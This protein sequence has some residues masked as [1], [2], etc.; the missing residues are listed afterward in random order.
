MSLK[1]YLFIA[2][3]LLIGNIYSQQG[4]VL[5]IGDHQISNDYLLDVYN[6]ISN[7]GV[8]EEVDVV[9]W[10]QGDPVLSTLLNYDAVLVWGHDGNLGSAFG[11]ALANYIDEGGGVVNALFSTAYSNSSRSLGIKGRFQSDKYYLIEST[12]QAF[13]R[14]EL[15]DLSDTFNF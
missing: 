14:I 4:K 11:D 12:S 7:I 15:S 10:S 6:K 2:V 8:F 1:K 13:K 3:F 5:I 9:D